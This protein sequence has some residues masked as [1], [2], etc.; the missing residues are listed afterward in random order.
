MCLIYDYM[1]YADIVSTFAL[2]ISLTL[3][4]IEL[5]RALQPLHF[6]V[7]HVTLIDYD[8]GIHY[9]LADIAIVNA[10]SISKTVYQIDFQPLK[11]FQIA[12]IDGVQD[13]ATGLVTF[14]PLGEGRRAAQVRLEDTASW[15]LDIEAH[16][17][18][19]VFLALS[20]SSIPFESP[21]DSLPKKFGYIRALNIHGKCIAKAQL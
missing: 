4:G 7:L 2:F 3:V 6:S 1:N 8:K 11:D 5:Y 15:P 16:H 10:S 19:S 12:L 21:Q 13:F 14:R 18:K 20:V 17:S 9:I